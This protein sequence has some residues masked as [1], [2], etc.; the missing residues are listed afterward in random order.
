MRDRTSLSYCYRRSLNQ[1]S[2][3]P[4]ASECLL[5]SQLPAT[6]IR[7]TPSHSALIESWVRGLSSPEGS[8]DFQNLNA[9]PFPSTPPSHTQHP[10]TFATSEPSRAHVLSVS[11]LSFCAYSYS[12][13]ISRYVPTADCRIGLVG[14]RR[15]FRFFIVASW[16][17]SAGCLW[18]RS[19]FGRNLSSARLLQI[20]AACRWARVAERTTALFVIFMM[21]SLA[22][23]TS[24]HTQFKAYP[25]APKSMTWASYSPKST[26]YSPQ[27]SLLL[28]A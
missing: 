1:A 28:L 22:Q 13:G 18:S 4:F 24:P 19:I 10:R 20:W 5:W 21:I 14:T 11:F 12:L 17:L 9:R 27:K 25:P 3:P 16:A 7:A 23:I 8:A 15:N 2:R 26:I 6:F